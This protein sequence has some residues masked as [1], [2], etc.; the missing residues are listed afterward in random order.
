MAQLEVFNIRNLPV[1]SGKAAIPMDYF[2]KGAAAMFVD[3]VS[4]VGRSSLRTIALGAP[5]YRDVYIGTHHV[6]H[7]PVSDLLRFRVFSIDYNYSS[8]S[9]LSPVLSQIIK[10]A[11]DRSNGDLFPSWLLQGY[12]LG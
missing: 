5:L 4:K 1:F 9:G 3:I 12:W 8:P 11:E 10:G 7:T 6:V 2:V